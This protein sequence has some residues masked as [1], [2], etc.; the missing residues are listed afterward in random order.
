MIEISRCD[1]RVLAD[2]PLGDPA[3]REVGVYLPPSY[4]GQKRFPVVIFL[5]GFTGTG[6]QL[7]N[8]GAW[9]VPLDR[10]LEALFAA[11]SA[12]ECIVVL[13]DCF[14]RYGGSPYVDSPAAGRHAPPLTQELLP[15]VE[16]RYR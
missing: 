8:R 3:S 2:N 12:R 7:L 1:S 16:S 11:G 10:R 9:Q 5:P 15:F 13:P 14:T 4:D 6:L